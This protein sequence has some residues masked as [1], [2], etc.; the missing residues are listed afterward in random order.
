MSSSL[1][2]AAI[3]A[4]L[5]DILQKGINTDYVSGARVTA[6]PPDKARARADEFPAQVNLFL[7]HIAVDAAW[8]NMD[9]PNRVKP[10]EIGHSPLALKLY[11][12]I[13]AYW[14]Q[15]EEEI[16]DHTNSEQ[17]LGSH[18]LLGKAMSIFHDN[19]I[20]DAKVINEQLKEGDLSIHHYD[21]LEKTRI[22]PQPLSLDEMSK[23]WTTFQT[24]YRTS[25][26]YEVSAVLIDSEKP[27]KSSPPVLRRGQ[28]DE[29]VSSQ[30]SSSPFL[31][32]VLPPEP[33]PSMRLG[34]DLTIL[35]D[36]LDGDGLVVRL[37]GALLLKPIEVMPLPD[38][39]KTKIKVKLTGIDK[40]DDAFITWAPGFYTA[41]VVVTR[42]SQPVWTT[43]EVPF[44]LSP[45]I[46]LIVPTQGSLDLTV[47][48]TP[49]IRQGQRALLILGDMQLSPVSISTPTPNPNDKPKDKVLPSTLI[50]S[51]K[52]IPKGKY[53]V[54]LRIDGVDSLPVIR[55]D[56][57]SPLEFDPNQ[58][59]TIQ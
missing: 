53:L 24:N 49:R 9:M 55:K 58:E 38:K 17:L 5:C 57:S 2:I 44:G 35:G 56:E 13:T 23:L 11:Y 4:K 18:R 42:K 19:A 21:Q 26:A 3:T 8:R 31:K 1:A 36:N 54:R 43:N 39:T 33:M 46:K 41:S 12:L 29:G 52:D 40:D 28:E 14:H 22:T 51:I 47:E 59:I 20:L 10:G 6:L 32:G 50:F 16:D 30:V 48:C 25:A 45:S 7:Y 37:S 15:T 34:E 27:V